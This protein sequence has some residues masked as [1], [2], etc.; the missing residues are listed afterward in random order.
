MYFLTV[1]LCYQIQSIKVSNSI[2]ENYNIL[3]IGSIFKVTLTTD[4]DRNMSFK[5]FTTICVVGLIVHVLY[6]TDTY[7]DYEVTNN[8][9]IDIPD[10]VQ[11]PTLS[12]CFFIY[13]LLDGG[14]TKRH[15]VRTLTTSLADLFKEASQYDDL[16]KYAVIRFPDKTMDNQ[17]DFNTS[18]RIREKVDISK[19]YAQEY[20]CY[21]MT[22]KV[23]GTY[24]F[25]RIST[26]YEWPSMVFVYRIR[27]DLT[28]KTWFMAP[29]I[30]ESHSYPHRELML[31]RSA[32]SD[33]SEVHVSYQNIMTYRLPAPYSTKCRNYERPLCIQEC[34]INLTLD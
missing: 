25:D 23:N 9:V 2:V 6:I 34:A 11:V 18:D 7:T 15:D 14:D 24:D 19:F 10:T 29:V 8:I 12:L 5:I 26:A 4:F 13:E 28:S 3:C 20:I 16:I 17:F 1:C 30:H 22:L 32:P 21:R 27:P 31:A 33:G